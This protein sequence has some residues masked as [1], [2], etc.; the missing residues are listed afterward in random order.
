MSEDAPIKLTP[1]LEAAART[2]RKGA[3]LVDVGTDHA[4]LPV[5]LVQTGVCPTAVAADIRSEYFSAP[6]KQLK[7][8]VLRTKFRFA[9]ATAFPAYRQTMCRML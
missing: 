8:T 9:C 7:N 5:Y 4:Y 6:K 2:V 1:R 3:K